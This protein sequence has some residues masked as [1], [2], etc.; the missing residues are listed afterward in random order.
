VEGYSLPRRTCWLSVF[1]LV[2]T[3][4]LELVQLSPLPPQD[5]VSTNFTTSA[6]SPLFYSDFTA[7]LMRIA[8]KQEENGKA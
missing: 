5:S 2:P 7:L 6:L 3:T 4:R 1:L 8:A